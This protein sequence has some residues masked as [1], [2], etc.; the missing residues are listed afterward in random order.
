MLRI[1]PGRRSLRSE[2]WMGESCAVVSRFPISE[3]TIEE[4]TYPTCMNQVR[5]HTIQQETNCIPYIFYVKSRRIGKLADALRREL[6][7]LSRSWAS[8]IDCRYW[9]RGRLTVPARIM[10][11]IAVRIPLLWLLYVICWSI[12]SV[13]KQSRICSTTIGQAAAFPSN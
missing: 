10:V 12:S 8:C 6:A 5:D 2:G 9:V 13:A 4:K 1:T 11:G 7:R 3:D